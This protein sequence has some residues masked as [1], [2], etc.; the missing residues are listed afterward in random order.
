MQLVN[1]QQYSKRVCIQTSGI[2]GVVTGGPGERR[3]ERGVSIVDRPA[4]DHVVV[5]V[6][7]ERHE[8]HPGSNSL[9]LCDVVLY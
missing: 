2:V 4:N 3:L 5:D 7:H 9:K 1:T 8:Y 6:H